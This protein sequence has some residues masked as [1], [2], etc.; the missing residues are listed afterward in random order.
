MEGRKGG[1]VGDGGRPRSADEDNFLFLRGGGDEE[2]RGRDVTRA[3][4]G[5]VVCL[6]R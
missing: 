3:G 4:R 6:L 2:G 1:D 5:S